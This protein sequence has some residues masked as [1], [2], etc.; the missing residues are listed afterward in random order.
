MSASITAR[1]TPCV[2]ATSAKARSTGESWCRVFPEE[3]EPGRMIAAGH[4][5]KLEDY[6]QD[7]ET[8][9]A[10]RLGYRITSKFVHTFFGRVFDSPMAV[11]TDNILKPELQ[12]PAVFAAGMKN[13]VEA[14]QRTAEAYFRDGTIQFACPPLRAL[15]HI[16]ARGSYN[17]LDA[18]SPELRR[19]FTREALLESD[20]YA[21]RL[22]IKQRRDV[23]LWRRHVESLRKF[24]AL[25]GHRE[26]A[27][28]LKIDERLVLAQRELSRVSRPEYLDDLQGTIGADPIEEEAVGVSGQG[29]VR[30]AE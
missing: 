3:R 16:M 20:W 14:Q 18:H 2:R 1:G 25:P 12:D 19:M 10:S 26:E 9:L 7:G 6:E 4:L 8:V 15:L 13:I 22:R 11:F 28:R 29:E 30:A 23:A 24:L 21:A 27:A 5:E 17:G